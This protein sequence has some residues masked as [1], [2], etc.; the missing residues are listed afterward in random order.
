MAT[1]TPPSK[2]QPVR[3]FRSSPPVFKLTLYSSSM[4]VGFG[5]EICKP[6][7]PRCD[8]CD[9]AAVSPSLCPS[10]RRGIVKK[11]ASSPVKRETGSSPS[12]KRRK[13]EDVDMSLVEVPRSPPKVVIELEETRVKLEAGEKIEGQV[14]EATDAGEKSLQESVTIKAEQSSPH[15]LAW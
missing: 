15:K 11:E 7:G 2:D 3:Y 10:A 1:E 9:V 14:S 8:L 6:V 5:Q 13:V 12:N 4:L